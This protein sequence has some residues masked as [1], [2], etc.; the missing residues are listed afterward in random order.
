MKSREGERDGLG[1]LGI[2]KEHYWVKTGVAEG[3]GM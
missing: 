1:V 3:L 2:V